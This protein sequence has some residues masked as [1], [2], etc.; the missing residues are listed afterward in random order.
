MEVVAR[1]GG[2][3]SVYSLLDGR[4]QTEGCGGT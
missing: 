4:A 2:R 3:D 1:T